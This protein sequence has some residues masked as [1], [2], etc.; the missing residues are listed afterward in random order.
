[1]STTGGLM[2]YYGHHNPGQD[3]DR[4]NQSA[5]YGLDEVTKNQKAMHLAQEYIRTTPLRNQV[6]EMAYKT[7]V[8]YAPKAYPVLWSIYSPRQDSA[9]PFQERL[10][11]GRDLLV[12]LTNVSYIL[13][14]LLSLGH[15][16]ICGVTLFICGSF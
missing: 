6:F 5:F 15:S 12:G 13:L 7:L 14:A 9:S 2:F 3:W 11:A 16:S 4:L 10:I 8:L 1:M